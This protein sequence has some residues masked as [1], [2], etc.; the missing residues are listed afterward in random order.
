MKIVRARLKPYTGSAEF[1]SLAGRIRSLIQ[2]NKDDD[3][4]FVIDENG[5]KTVKEYGKDMIND[6][7][8]GKS[9][10]ILNTEYYAK[11]NN[12]GTIDVIT[13]NQINESLPREHS[14][15]QLK[16]IRKISKGIDI[17]DRI[18]DLKKQGANIHYYQN[19]ID[20]GIESF[21]EFEKNNKKFVP[22]WNL[23]GMI[24]PYSKK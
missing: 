3:F 24:S 16:R 6:E 5:I 15:E 22:S 10:Q 23:K 13:E 19:P 17:G 1:I 20:S 4:H 14:I 12:D 8:V 21:E 7:L 9:I 18:P 2:N 11:F